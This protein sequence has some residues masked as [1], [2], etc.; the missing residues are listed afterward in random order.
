MN[1]DHQIMANQVIISH[2]KE[3][4]SLMGVLESFDLEK[5]ALKYNGFV[6]QQYGGVEKLE[7]LI[8]EKGEFVNTELDKWWQSYDYWFQK[9]QW[10]SFE[11][12]SIPMFIS[13]DSAE[14]SDLT[15]T[16][17][18]VQ[19]NDTIFYVSG[20]MSGEKPTGY[21]ARV[22]PSR[23]IVWFQKLNLEYIQTRGNIDS[24]KVR[25]L[26]GDEPG[27]TVFY[28]SRRKDAGIDD[29]SHVALVARLDEKGKLAWRK[30][31]NLEGYPM[32]IEFDGMAGE[33]KVYYSLDPEIPEPGGYKYLILDASGKLKN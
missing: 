24:M 10:A 27:K 23:E 31:L 18:T 8:K 19:N 17:F 32:E 7:G 30:T 1:V 12:D 21:F 6:E 22:L 2:L 9:G 5:E 25:I 15:F 4:D 14:L 26:S 20:R 16:T 13:S 29:P 11:N 3:A 33:T 28:Y